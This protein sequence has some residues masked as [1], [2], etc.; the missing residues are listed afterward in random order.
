[1]LIHY[2]V[3]KNYRFL[4]ERNLLNDKDLD[5]R[6][7]R[8]YSSIERIY[9]YIDM[10]LPVKLFALRRN[11]IL[12]YE[13]RFDINIPILPFIIVRSRETGEIVETGYSPYK[14]LYKQ[15]WGILIKYTKL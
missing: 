9:K 1:M 13:E 2:D 10:G 11:D 8:K 7:R 14:N 6:E 4:V 5:E 3:L 15:V 12:E